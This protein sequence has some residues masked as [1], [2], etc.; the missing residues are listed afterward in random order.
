MEKIPSFSNPM[1]NFEVNS[2]RKL[3]KA[4]FIFK[5]NKFFLN[6]LFCAVLSASV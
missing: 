1:L 3:Y 2:F 4:A 6:D 5:K